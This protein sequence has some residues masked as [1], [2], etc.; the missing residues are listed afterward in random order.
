MNS[1]EKEARLVRRIAKA[2]AA[3]GWSVVRAAA[4]KSYGQGKIDAVAINPTKREVWLLQFKA[5]K[6]GGLT[7]GQ[8]ERAELWQLF[9]P[10]FAKQTY[11]LRCEL[12]THPNDAA[13]LEGVD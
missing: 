13:L 7:A 3:K 11:T 9:N 4:S 5:Y 10:D 2:L 8:K 1:S 6:K 12:I